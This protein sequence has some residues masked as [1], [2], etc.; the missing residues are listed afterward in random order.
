MRAWV[1][2]S[3]VWRGIGYTI[4]LECENA[5]K[6]LGA[7]EASLMWPFWV[8]R[9]GTFSDIVAKT[10]EG[11]LRTHKLLSENPEELEMRCPVHVEGT[12]E[13]L[14]CNDQVEPLPG[15]TFVMKTP[16]G[17]GYGARQG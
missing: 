5:A 17:G 15:G 7:K 10:P 11:D 13:P 16:G 2:R 3:G 4:D 14:A 1:T 6:G 8:D 9:G 12:V